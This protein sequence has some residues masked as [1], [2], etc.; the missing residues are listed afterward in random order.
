MRALILARA[1]IGASLVGKGKLRVINGSARA[2]K[3]IA[4]APK[5]QSERAANYAIISD[6]R[7]SPLTAT[8]AL[9]V[10]KTSLRASSC[11][12]IIRS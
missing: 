4:P 1:M 5:V 12:A 6:A 11:N 3:R 7:S 2:A 10:A 8:N 9:H